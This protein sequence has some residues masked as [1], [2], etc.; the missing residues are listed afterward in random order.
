MIQQ[1]WQFTNGTDFKPYK[2]RKNE[3][4]VHDSCILLGSWVVV[5]S[6][7]QAKILQ[8]LHEGLPGTNHL[9]L[10]LCAVAL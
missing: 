7:G 9:G 8:E 10:Q 6:S 1:G 5:P 4:N 2:D 3:L